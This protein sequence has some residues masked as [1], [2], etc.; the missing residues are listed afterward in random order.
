MF[1]KVDTYKIRLLLVYSL[2]P[3]FGKVTLPEWIKEALRYHYNDSVEVFACG[4]DNE[5]N[6]QDS[7]VF[8]DEVNNIVQQFGIDVVWDIEGGATSLDFMFKRFPKNISVPKV[9]WA[10][11]THQYLEAQVEKSKYFDLVFSAQK[12]ALPYLGPN[13]RWLP[14]GAS[15][16]EVDCQLDRSI[17][18]GFV[19]NIFDGLHKRRKNV[20]ERLIK[21]V[22]GFK[23]Y[24]NVFLDDK[25]RLTSSMKIMV[26]VSL[27]NDI[28]FRVFETLACGAM[29]ITDKVFNNGMEELFEDGKHLVTFETEDELIEKINYY[30]SHDEERERIAKSGQ[31]HV[32]KYYTHKELLHHVLEAMKGLVEEHRM[33]NSESQSSLSTFVCWCEGSLGDSVHPLYVKCQ[34]CG[35]HIVRN[36]LSSEQ[37]KEFYTLNGYWHEYQEKVDNYPS[38][39][40]RSYDDFGNRIPVW[41]EIL[42]RYKPE[43]EYLLE[44]GC[45]HGGFLHYAQERGAK[46]VVGVEVDEATCD[47]ARKR[48]NLGHVVSGLFPDISL[49]YEKY[50]AITG[51]D[52]IEHFA[53]P[54]K[55]ITAVSEILKDDGVFVFQTPCYRGESETWNQFKPI[56]HLYLYNEVSVKELFCSCGL[57]IIEILP[58]YFNDDMFVIGRKK[59][60]VRNNVCAQSNL[61]LEN[62]Q[63]NSLLFIRTDAIGDNVLASAMLPHVRVHYPYAKI[64]IFCQDRVVDLYEACPYVDGIISYNWRKAFHEEP[65]R[66]EILDKVQAINADITLNSV[67][68]RDALTDYFAIGS[69]APERI[70][71]HGDESNIRE[72]L[73]DENNSAYTRIID[74]EGSPKSEMERHRDFLRG[75][76]IDAPP[77]QPLVW[78]TDEDERFA[79]EFFLRHSLDPQKTVAF[80]PSG[81]WEGKFY[82]QYPEALT[83]LF[84]EKGLSVIMFGGGKERDLNDRLLDELGV[85]GVNAAGETTIRQ[86]A[87]IIRRCRIGVGADTGT[88]HIACAVGTPHVVLLWGG[89]FGRF[90]PYSPLTSVV[91][92]PLECYGCNWLCPYTRPHCVKDIHPSVVETAIRETLAAGSELPRIF[93]QDYDS[94]RP[95]PGEPGWDLFT[96]FIDRRAVAIVPVSG[97]QVSRTVTFS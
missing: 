78:T 64:I 45:A 96:R 7:P 93:A 63:V 40:Q 56:E 72:G 68:S 52:V 21:D 2:H 20:V 59:S 11:D 29:L 82:N 1:N 41:H 14:A 3:A 53:D 39:E 13:T 31:R 10:I 38:I 89:H 42:C 79:E 19:G 70:A 18:V 86:T 85:P 15:I 71:L 23:H 66:Q 43:P 25:A 24:S 80:Y 46:N 95:G 84:R 35:T 17:D 33:I 75:L 49:P 92:L 58:G 44:I 62:T 97:G 91:C 32:L 81:Q 73:R 94:W 90:F 9:Y 83:D 51:F 50:D 61:A 4:P 34:K 36:K 6:I 8:Y 12:N 26:N 87:A 22:P 5:I 77:L 47:F 30:I 57:E 55:G 60:L 28:N 48:F 54:I 67:F 27:N 69:F 76:G 16:H 65:Y 88:A 37:L 74:I